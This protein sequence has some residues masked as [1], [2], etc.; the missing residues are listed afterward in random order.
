M[1]VAAI[2]LDK[3]EPR[4]IIIQAG[5]PRRA[6]SP[7]WAYSWSEDLEPGACAGAR[8]GRILETSPPPDGTRETCRASP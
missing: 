3:R 4:G 1:T 6:P 8:G 5:P 7:F 2:P